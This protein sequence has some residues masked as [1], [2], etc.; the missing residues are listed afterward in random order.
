MI[1][2]THTLLTDYF[3]DYWRAQSAWSPELGID[4]MLSTT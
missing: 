3:V 4:S 2:T 1:T